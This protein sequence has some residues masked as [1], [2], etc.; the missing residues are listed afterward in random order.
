MDFELD[1]RPAGAAAA[2]SATSPSGSARRRCVRAVVDRRRRRQRALEDAR[3]ARLAEPDRARGR[4]RHGADRGR[5]GHRPRGAGPGRRPDAVPRHDEP[6]RAARARVRRRRRRAASCSARCAPAAPGAVAFAADDVRARRRR[7]R[8]GAAT[9]PP[10]HVLDGDRADELAVVAATDDG[11]GVFV[12]P[13]RRRPAH[14]ADRVRRHR[15]TSPTSRLD[16]VA[17]RRP[18]GPS[19]ARASPAASTGPARRPSPAWPRSWS[20]PRSGCF[21]LV[22]DHVQER[23]QFGVPIGSF[24]AVK[25]MAVDVYVAIERARALC[26]FAGLAI[27]EDDDRRTAGG[28]DGQGGRRRLPAHRRPARHPA[29]RRPRATR[30]RTTCSSTCGGPRSASCSSARPPSTG[31][32]RPASLAGSP[33]RWRR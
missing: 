13:R 23:H 18:T 8:L 7:R 9:A 4:R 6:V 1:R 24:Q 17:R 29:L 11:V 26:Q 5:A 33:R 20:A 3:R 10:A 27:A 21:E 22:L 28:V 2:S 30:G 16:G 19:S 25:H 12:V 31:P 14:P 15:S 32:G